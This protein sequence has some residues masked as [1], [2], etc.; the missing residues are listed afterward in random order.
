MCLNFPALCLPF[1]TLTVMGWSPQVE[2][3]NSGSMSVEDSE[4]DDDDDDLDEDKK[5]VS[6]LNQTLST[7]TS[8]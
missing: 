4:D 3:V 6:D 1:L 2:E 7:F 5:F 8:F